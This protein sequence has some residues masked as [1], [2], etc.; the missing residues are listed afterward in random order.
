M[1]LAELASSH[2]RGVVLGA[3]QQLCLCQVGFDRGAVRVFEQGFGE[4][5]RGGLDRIPVHL[6][7]EQGHARSLPVVRKVVY[8][9]RQ[10]IAIALRS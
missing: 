9:E 8:T 4:V 1:C 10:L 2:N 3:A 6:E 5:H 7:L